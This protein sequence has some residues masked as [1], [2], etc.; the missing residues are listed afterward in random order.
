MA[1]TTGMVASQPD[2]RGPLM[3]AHA[4]PARAAAASPA[5]NPAREP[6]RGPTRDPAWP[7]RDPAWSARDLAWP[8]RTGAM[9][10]P[11]SA[12]TA[13]TD[14]VPGVESLLEPGA[15]VALVPVRDSA[16]AADG[17]AQPSGKTQLAS[18]LAASLWQSGD[19]DFL[20]WV[21]AADRA[22]VLSGYAAAA[23]RLGLD[24]GGD[25]ESVAARFLAWLKGAARPWLVVL[26]DLRNAADLDG[27]W[28]EGPAGR[29]VITAPDARAV[30]AGRRAVP[31]PVPAFSLREAI[32]YLFDRLTTDPNQRG[33]AY[34]LAD[35]L[36]CGPVAL[37]HAAAVMADSGIGCRDYQD[38]FRRQRERLPAVAGREPPA[39][40]VTWLLSAD[41]AAG[42]LPGEGT[43]LLLV[44][45]ALVDGHGIPRAVLTAPATVRYLAGGGGGL[46]ADPEHAWRA[47]L[48]L[49]RAGLVGLGPDDDA[50]VWVSPALQAA[51]RAAAAPELLDLAAR[52]AAN[53]VLEA[54]PKDQPRSVLAARMRACAESL[55]RHAGDALWGGDSCHR[56]LLAVGQSA[57]AARLAGPAID[58]WREITA[59]C[60][61][62]LG[63]DHPDTL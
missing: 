45:A 35:D 36:G 1:R 52:A 47:A 26:D 53:A 44:L 27:L 46:P 11:A 14:S 24:D 12:F 54:W 40:A 15:A 42:L 56:V 55:L 62:L 34:D 25:G 21:N 29:L 4:D 49:G 16:V 9:P 58:W 43:W 28:P 23:A 30:P 32:A 60:E 39:A 41:Y 3:A 50:A 57:A 19:I 6:T 2:R 31:V 22:S 63:G 5:N 48:A 10:P 59:R 8:I 13:R 37:G 38:Y 7:A 17:W 20:A 18:H 61:R 51:V 33:G